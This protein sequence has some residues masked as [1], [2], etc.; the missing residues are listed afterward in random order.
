MTNHQWRLAFA[1]DLV[2]PYT[3]DSTPEQKTAASHVCQRQPDA[4]V[5]I[6]MLG[7]EQPK[8]DQ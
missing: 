4:Q 7:L 3:A 5:L 8:E 2:V 6:E 1:Q